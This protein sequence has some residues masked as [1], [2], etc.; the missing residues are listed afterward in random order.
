M[1]IKHISQCIIKCY[2]LVYEF[3][4]C[5]HSNLGVVLIIDLLSETYNSNNLEM[6]M[7]WIVYRDSLQVSSE[8]S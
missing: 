4:C 2:L 7:K 5:N 3:T 8:V 6:F 1:C